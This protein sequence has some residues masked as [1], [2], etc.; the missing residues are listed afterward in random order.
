MRGP[1]QVSK[2]KKTKVPGKD[3]I[4]TGIPRVTINVHMPIYL[5]RSRLEKVSAT[6]ALPNAAAG[7][8]KKAVRA[9]HAAIEPYVGLFAQPTLQTKLS[10]TDKRKMGRRPNRLDK[11]FHKKGAPPKTAI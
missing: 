4:P 10:I 9:L 1:D 11:G 3:I 6:T 5:A 2:T 8:M 7:E